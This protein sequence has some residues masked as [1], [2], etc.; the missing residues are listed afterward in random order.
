MN[1]HEGHDRVELAGFVFD[2]KNLDLTD[3]SGER[4]RL[5][6][7]TMAVLACLAHCADRVV[8]KDELMHA[9]WPNLAVTDD[10][11]VQCIV[12]LRRVLGDRERRVVQTVPRRGYCLAVNR[13]TRSTLPADA[14]SN[15]FPQQIQ[16][17][18]STDGI[19]IAYASS[20][21]GPPVVRTA[22]WMTHLEWDWR[23][24]IFGEFIARLSRHNRLIRYDGRGCGLSDRGV[25]MASL[26]DEVRDLEAVVDAAGLEHFA[27]LG[28]SQGGAIAIRYAARHPERVSRLITIGGYARGALCRGERSIPVESIA[29][30]CK[31]LEDGWGDANSAFRQVWTSRAFPGATSQ[32][33]DSYNEMQRLSCSPRDAAIIYRMNAEY[34]TSTDLSLV[35]CPTLVLHSPDDALIPFEEGRLIATKIQGALLEPFSSPNHQPLPGEPAFEQVMQRIDEF[36]GGQPDSA[37]TLRASSP[38]TPDLRSTNSTTGTATANRRHP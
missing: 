26:D 37:A 29:A 23:S 18:T 4:V 22:Q 5:R 14:P 30:F 1:P 21:D 16:F 32:Q 3:S 17:A 28:R 31:V 25:P 38:S 6:P 24:L 33:Q 36:L 34:D 10:S 12:E 8:T 2:L 15:G 35:R 7:Q 9:V 19:R 20:G 27:L 11:L 13:S